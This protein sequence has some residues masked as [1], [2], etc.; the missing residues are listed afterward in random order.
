MQGTRSTIVTAAASFAV[1]LGVGS[2]AAASSGHGSRRP[3]TTTES[4]ETTTP[5]PN[6]KPAKADIR[7]HRSEGSSTTETDEDT[8]TTV[9]EKPPA[10]VR[11]RTPDSLE[12]DIGDDQGDDQGDAGEEA[13]ENE[14][15]QLDERDEKPPK[16]VD[17]SRDTEVEDNHDGTD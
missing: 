15:A 14:N 8:T 12:N 16:A 17:D 3:G 1:V 4:T 13:H 2:V 9:E 11:V 10:V 5:A 6:R 7:V